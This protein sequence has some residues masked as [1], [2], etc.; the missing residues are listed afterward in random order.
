[1]SSEIS[2]TGSTALS[3]R[4]PCRIVPRPCSPGTPTSGA[5][6]AGVSKK[7]FDPT[8]SSPFSLTKL[9][10]VIWPRFCGS[11]WFSKWAKTSPAALMDRLRASAGTVM[12]GATGN[13]SDVTIR[14]SAE[15]LRPPSRV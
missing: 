13:P 14:P 11:I 4:Y 8:A 2:R 10:S 9:A 15:R 6:E 3:S 1:M 12:P 5:P 7:R